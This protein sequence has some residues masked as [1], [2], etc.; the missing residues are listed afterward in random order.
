MFY[1]N[2][3]YI[4]IVGTLLTDNHSNNTMKNVCE[5]IDKQDTVCRRRFL[6]NDL[7]GNNIIVLENYFIYLIKI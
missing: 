7:P 1:Y 4:C 6:Y 5:N 3:L 2:L